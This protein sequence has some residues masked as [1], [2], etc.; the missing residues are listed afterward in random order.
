MT[1]TMHGYMIYRLQDELKARGGHDVSYDVMSA[2]LSN[3]L[4]AMDGDVLHG[5][6]IE[7]PSGNR[8]V[9]RNYQGK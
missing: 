5:E 2:A 9:K 7:L 3:V 4:M 6:S 8:M 1:G